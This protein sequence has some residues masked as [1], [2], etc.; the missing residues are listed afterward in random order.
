MTKV[1]AV[2]VSLLLS[3]GLWLCG[4]SYALCLL[5]R[6]LSSVGLLCQLVL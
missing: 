3:S 4:V 5:P 1:L 6:V 2:V